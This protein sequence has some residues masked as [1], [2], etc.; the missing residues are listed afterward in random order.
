MALKIKDMDVELSRASA[1]SV[2]SCAVS[3]NKSR[4]KPST[5][6]LGVL[7]NDDNEVEKSVTAG[8]LVADKTPLHTFVVALLI[9]ILSHAIAGMPS[10]AFRYV[11]VRLHVVL[12]VI[13]PL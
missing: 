8:P 5:T 9:A 3:V 1:I 12:V 10:G 7:V 13:C 6:R 11:Y 4:N 2:A